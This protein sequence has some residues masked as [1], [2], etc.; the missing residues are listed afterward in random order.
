MK[1]QE[2]REIVISKQLIHRD[3][4]VPKLLLKN[5]DAAAP[6]VTKKLSK[7]KKE[8]LRKE[9]EAEKDLENILA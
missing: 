6:E 5:D 9:T 1:E 4:P 7:E 2:E 3:I 8:A